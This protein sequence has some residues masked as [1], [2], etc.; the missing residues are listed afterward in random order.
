MNYKNKNGAIERMKCMRT[1]VVGTRESKLAVTQ[2]KWVIEQLKTQGVKNNI[3]IKYISTKGDRNQQVALS[4]VGGAG[5]FI[6]DIEN[7]L[8]NKEIDFAVHSLKDL[9]VELPREFTIAAIPPREDAR[10]A[11]IGRNEQIINELPD[12][13]VIGTSS[14]RRAAQIK[15]LYPHI[16][17]RWI[18]GAVDVRLKQLEEGK[19]DGIIL[20]VSGLKRLGLEHVITDY[21]PIDQFTPAVGQG[22]L[23]IECRTDDDEVIQVLR[24]LNNT[25][26]EQAILAERAFIRELDKEDK[27]PIGACATV[28]GDT[29]SLFTSVA[30]IDGETVLTYK[31]EG[32]SIDEV[33]D[34]AVQ[35]L[36]DAG[37]EK[38]I[39][40][41]IMEIDQQ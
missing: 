9:P 7:A 41:A 8:S 26:D 1:L 4:K 5:I 2:T 21:L 32:N 17:T 36:R 22:A 23:A 27:A 33:V 38:L 34:N 12:N 11:F 6:D 37:A 14:A 31:A 15:A 24:K 35:Y 19:Y 18:R 20:A 25:N 40:D 16:E 29:I 3:D 30:S 28:E 39:K 13:A 10:D